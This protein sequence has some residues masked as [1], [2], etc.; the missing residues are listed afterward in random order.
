[1]EDEVNWY[2]LVSLKVILPGK[3]MLQDELDLLCRHPLRRRLLPKL[4]LDV[5][6]LVQMRRRDLKSKGNPLPKINS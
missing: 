1:M 6:S 4:A 2:Q 3:K 5:I